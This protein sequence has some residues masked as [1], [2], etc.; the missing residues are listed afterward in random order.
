MLVRDGGGITSH[1]GLHLNSV[2]FSGG[3][4]LARNR[5]CQ[6]ILCDLTSFPLTVGFST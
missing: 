5:H 6:K 3:T 4:G 2:R 1:G